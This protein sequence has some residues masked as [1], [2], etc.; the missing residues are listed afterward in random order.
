MPEHDLYSLLSYQYTLPQELIAQH[1]CE[2]RDNSRLMVVDRQSGKITT[3]TFRDIVH[4]LQPGDGLVFNDTRVIPARLL[5]R[6][7]TG[8]QAEV[9]LT[10]RHADGSWDALVRPGKKLKVGAMVEFNSRLSG[11]V[12]AVCEDGERRIRFHCQGDLEAVLEESGQI[13]L[14]QYIKRQP[15]KEDYA[16]YQTVYAA[17]PG[18]VAAPTAGLHFTEELLQTLE[19][20]GVSRTQITLHVGVGTFKPVQTTDIRAH[21]MHHERYVVTQEAAAALNSARE[22]RRQVC[23]GTTCCRTLESAAQN[24][25]KIHAGEYSTDIFIYPGYTFK[26]VRSMLTNFHLPGSTLLMLVSAFAGYEL[27][28]EAYRKAVEERFRFFSYGDAMLIL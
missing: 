24:D 1:P 4:F 16:R 11:E 25:G 13:P 2:P 21:R 28:M 3:T 19:D 6:L 26:Y 27:T 14:P 12:I 20:R 9:F 7:S 22:T 18:A 15:D 17:N 5:G 8:G 10:R 23:V